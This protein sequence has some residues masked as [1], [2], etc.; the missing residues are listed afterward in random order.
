MQK[1][2]RDQNGS[3]I[4]VKLAWGMPSDGLDVQ[5]RWASYFPPTELDL[6]TKSRAAQLET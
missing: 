4:T 6:H 2:N 1:S 3:F 5:H